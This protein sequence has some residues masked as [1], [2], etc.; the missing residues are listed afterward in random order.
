MCLLGKKVPLFVFLLVL[1]LASVSAIDN[2][3]VAVV[4]LENQII[5]NETA[6]FRVEVTNYHDRSKEFKLE[7]VGYPFWDMFTDPLQNPITID[8]PPESTRSFTLLVRPLHIT[9]VDTYNLDPQVLDIATGKR[10]SAPLTIGIKSTAP[11]IGGYVPTVTTFL[12]FPEVIDPR[13]PVKLTLN[14]NNQNILDYPDLEV[15]VSSN[16]IGGEYHYTLGPKEDKT[17]EIPF[18]LNPETPPQNDRLVLA[19]FREDRAIINPIVKDFTIE[20]YFVKTEEEPF[21]SLLRTERTITLKSNNPQYQGLLEVET[22]F[23]TNLFTSTFPKA[24]FNVQEDRKILVWDVDLNDNNEMSVRI[25]ENFRPLVIIAI[26]I[27]IMIGLYFVFRSPIIVRKEITSTVTKEGGITDLKVLLRVKNRGK[28]ILNEIEVADVVPKIAQVE[29]HVDIGTM[30]P[31]K[32][33]KHPRK[34]MIIKWTVKE[35]EPSE[36]IVLSYHMKSKLSILGE[37]SLPSATA[38]VRHKKSYII[39]NSNRV[40]VNS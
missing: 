40:S 9:S 16:L 11:L 24:T 6:S 30:K 18:E 15:R 28:A 37:F 8:V 2:F 39:T 5:V 29:K 4:T 25:V 3:N 36:S 12:D 14:L 31:E 20:E 17:I 27:L 7:K 34:G 32:I 19:L 38:R 26:V 1:S 22:D 23:F 21:Q 10:Q 13:K 33:T 35:L